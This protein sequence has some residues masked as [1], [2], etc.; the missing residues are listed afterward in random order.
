MDQNG[1]RQFVTNQN[2]WL[3][4]CISMADIYEMLTAFVFYAAH[5]SKDSYYQYYSLSTYMF[6]YYDLAYIL[7]FTDY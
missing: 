5:T 2:N 3:K 7:I 6:D 1:V 4:I